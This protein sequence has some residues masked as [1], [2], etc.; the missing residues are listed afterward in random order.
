MI[1]D[2]VYKI[3][4]DKIEN[5]N[6]S[7]LLFSILKKFINRVNKNYL[8]PIIIVVYTY[9]QNNESF[10]IIK[11]LIDKIE[12]IS[13]KLSENYISIKFI[14]F[15]FCILDNEKLINKYFSNLF[16]ENFSVPANYKNECLNCKYIYC[17]KYKK[18]DLILKPFLWKLMKK[19]DLIII[20]E[21]VVWFLLSIWFEKKDFILIFPFDIRNNFETINI[22][23]LSRTKIWFFNKKEI[24]INWEINKCDMASNLFFKNYIHQ[25]FFDKLLIKYSISIFLKF[26]FSNIQDNFFD[27]WNFYFW[28]RDIENI[29]DYIEYNHYIE[30][31]KMLIWDII[32]WRVDKNNSFL[33][34]VNL[35]VVNINDIKNIKENFSEYIVLI[36]DHNINFFIPYIYKFK[37]FLSYMKE[38]DIL[39][40]NTTHYIIISKEIWA[41]YI[42]WIDMEYFFWFTTEIL[43]IDFNTWI[44]KRIW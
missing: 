18:N 20:Y 5:N 40:N 13:N 12:L 37:Y 17:L 44:I 8:N 10:F 14:N 15:P 9:E 24:F 21:E 16:T 43:N 7:I 42:D 35:K 39:N 23:L 2:S 6:I 38:M 3:N 25:K 11:N 26:S 34:N 36:W 4:I 29:N 19:S 31:K 41:S 22:E 1:N 27:F 30:Y 33:W 28:I 32:K